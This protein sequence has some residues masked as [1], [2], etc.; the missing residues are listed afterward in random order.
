MEG[1]LLT[2]AF[3]TLK[4]CPC[5]ISIYFNIIS[6]TITERSIILRVLW[7]MDLYEIIFFSSLC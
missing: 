5:F 6:L 7:F 3:I 1:V 4:R 2:Y